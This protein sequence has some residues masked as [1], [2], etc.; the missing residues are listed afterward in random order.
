MLEKLTAE[1]FRR[2]LEQPFAVIFSDGRLPLRL[3][4]VLTP[5]QEEGMLEARRAR[6][7]RPVPFNLVFRGPLS[8]LLPQRTYRLANELLGE[9]DLFLVPLGPD[10]EGQRYEAVFN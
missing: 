2:A 5:A 6:G 3:A 8:P 4:E 10:A 9:L 7:V 1:D